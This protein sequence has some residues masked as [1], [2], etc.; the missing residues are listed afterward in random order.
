ME[1]SGCGS[2][3]HLAWCLWTTGLSSVLQGFQCRCCSRACQA[4]GTGSVW[5]RGSASSEHGGHEVSQLDCP[6][7]SQLCLLHPALR[8]WH[9]DGGKANAVLC[10]SQATVLR[11]VQGGFGPGPILQG[12]P[13]CQTSRDTNA[14]SDVCSTGTK[15]LSDPSEAQ[16]V[17]VAAQEGSGTSSLGLPGGSAGFRAGNSKQGKE[18]LRG[19]KVQTVYGTHCVWGLVGGQMRLARVWGGGDEAG[20]GGRSQQHFW[21]GDILSREPPGWGP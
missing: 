20:G 21:K 14:A 6:A 9:P 1:R 12:F 2:W 18:P 17:A 15:V 13:E 11:V 7:V 10:K 19:R 8:Q 16:L 4:R 5:L 3:A